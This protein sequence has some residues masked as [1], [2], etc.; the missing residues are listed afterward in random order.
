MK[1]V[2]PEH[3]TIQAF[4]IIVDINGFTQMVAKA[5]NNSVAQFV[6]EALLGPVEA[7]EHQDGEVVAFMRDAILGIVPAHSDIAA[8]CFDIAIRLN[9]QC[10]Y[11]T[12]SQRGWPDNWAF[13]PGGLSMK[14]GVEFGTLDCS[15]IYSRFL[16]KRP[17]LVGTAINHASRIIAAGVGNRCHIGPVAASMNPFTQYR[18]GYPL[19][20]Q[21]K[22]SDKNGPYI[23]H[24]F[25]LGQLWV[26]G[27]RG[28]GEETYLD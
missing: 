14:I 1:I 9:R 25:Y 4:A 2:I 27:R 17:H 12:S 15:T 21:G 23:Y 28:N 20:A 6:S 26:E 10:D 11:I 19:K 5:E 7:I 13:A 3:G 18:I 16:G 22:G 24:E 8:V